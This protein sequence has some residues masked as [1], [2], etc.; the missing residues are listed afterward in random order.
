MTNLLMEE[1]EWQKKINKRSW[2]HK[3]L[4]GVESKQNLNLQKIDKN[5]K[6]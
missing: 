3:L 5:E 1:N 2:K 6:D 4:V